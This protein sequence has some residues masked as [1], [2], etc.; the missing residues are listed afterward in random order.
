M[1]GLSDISTEDLEH[2]LYGPNITEIYRKLSTE[3]SQTD[4]Y[5]ILLLIYMHSSFTDFESYLRNLGSLSGNDIQMI[6]K[7]CNSIFTTYQIPAGG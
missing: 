3:K 7:Q 6:L 5:H 4:G 1:L 2:E